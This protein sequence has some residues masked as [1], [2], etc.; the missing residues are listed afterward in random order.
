MPAWRP[1]WV[2]YV[3]PGT[4]RRSARMGPRHPTG[5]TARRAGL[6]VLGGP[7]MTTIGAA[8]RPASWITRPAPF[9][10][11]GS[12]RPRR[13][14]AATAGAAIPGS[15]RWSHRRPKS[16]HPAHFCS[17]THP[18]TPGCAGYSARL[19]PKTIEQLR[20][21]VTSIVDTAV[22][23][24]AE[25]EPQIDIL[26]DLAYPVTLAVIA[27]LLDVGTDGAQQF[28]EQT[29]TWSAC[30]KSTPPPRT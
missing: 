22:D 14:C 27:E 4:G 16:C 30:W 13:S 19:R 17:P 20:P 5:H 21:R 11:P 8:T 25:L 12:A 7:E 29:R 9:E 26:A 24:L 2:G 23:G 10:S 15:A 1:S 3:R 28:A 6:R 18:S